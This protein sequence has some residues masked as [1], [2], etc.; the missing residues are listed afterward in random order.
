MK[1][2]N[3]NVIIIP[4]SKSLRMINDAGLASEWANFVEDY[5]TS[6]IADKVVLAK[7]AK[8]LN[9]DAIF[10]G[11]LVNVYQRDGGGFGS[12]VRGLTRITLG[13]SIVETKTAKTIWEASSD[14]ILGTSNSYGEAPPIKDAIDL[15]MKKVKDNIPSL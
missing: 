8:A 2:K 4:P 15:A 1:K 12:S 7:L 5:Y 6:G 10:Q 13:F 14:G 3:P 9:A 11:Q